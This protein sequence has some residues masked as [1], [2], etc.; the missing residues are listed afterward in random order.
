MSTN[1]IA[2]MAHSS[3]I[4]SAV[5]V[6]SLSVFARVFR[7]LVTTF[8]YPRARRSRAGVT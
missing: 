6:V 8:R 3:A 1:A 4:A 5:S 7:W 2:G